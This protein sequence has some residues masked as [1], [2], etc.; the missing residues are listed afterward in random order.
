MALVHPCSKYPH[1]RREKWCENYLHEVKT[2][3]KHRHNPRPFVSEHM[4]R[5]IWQTELHV[6]TTS[7]Y[8]LLNSSLFAHKVHSHQ[9]V[10]SP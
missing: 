7:S 4:E 3:P 1:K 10:P 8:N 6:I 2:T 5:F 9:Y